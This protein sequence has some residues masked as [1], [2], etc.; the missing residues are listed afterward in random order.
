MCK[1]GGLL[2]TVPFE[3]LRS[4]TDCWGRYHKVKLLF[5]ENRHRQR[6]RAAAGVPLAEAQGVK[7]GVANG[8]GSVSRG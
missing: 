4:N 1:E 5:A 2:G 7:G 3:S 6:P 8:S